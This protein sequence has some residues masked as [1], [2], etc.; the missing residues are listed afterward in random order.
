MSWMG[1]SSNSWSNYHSA[2]CSCT[3]LPT[4]SHKGSC[5]FH[6]WPGMIHTPCPRDSNSLDVWWSYSRQEHFQH[7]SDHPCRPQTMH[8]KSQNKLVHLKDKIFKSCTI[9]KI[10]Q[11]V[12]T[13]TI[14][15]PSDILQFFFNNQELVWLVINSSNLATLMCDSRGDTVRRKK[16]FITIRSHK[17]KRSLGY[18][19][20]PCNS[21]YVNFITV[22]CNSTGCNMYP[23]AIIDYKPVHWK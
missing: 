6:T 7:K 21:M 15:I 1:P 3:T 18:S 13:N 23:Y 22:H 16:M 19:P 11:L 5:H 4:S 2:G 9:P 8:H 10:L 20:N 12:S 17:I 14:G